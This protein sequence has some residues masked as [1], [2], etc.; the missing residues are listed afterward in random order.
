MIP[1]PHFPSRIS[2]VARVVS[3]FLVLALCAAVLPQPAPALAA[4]SKTPT[5]TLTFINSVLVNVQVTNFPGYETYYVRAG[6]GNFYQTRNWNRLGRI[7]TN[8]NG[9]ANYSYRL[10]TKL[11]KANQLTVC[12]KDVWNDDSICQTVPKTPTR[13]P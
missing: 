9:V 6:E 13:Q 4:T 3:V 5:M 8:K 10:P 11:Q 1:T 7:R 12:L 2:R